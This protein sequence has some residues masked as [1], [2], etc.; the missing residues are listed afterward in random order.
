MIQTNILK[1]LSQS[2][3][4]EPHREP[5]TEADQAAGL[6][7]ADEGDR[8]RQIRG[9]PAQEDCVQRPEQASLVQGQGQAR[10]GQSVTLS[11]CMPVF[12]VQKL[13]RSENPKV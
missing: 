1:C 12:N 8:G 2:P 11:P 9:D 7:R 10:T 3:E 4:A 13:F 6:E 5:E